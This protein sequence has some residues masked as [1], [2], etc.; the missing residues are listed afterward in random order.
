MP[1]SH[2]DTT[3]SLVPQNSHVGWGVEV[4][5]GRGADCSALQRCREVEVQTAL[6][7]RGGGAEVQG[8]EV[9]GGH[10]GGVEDEG[11]DGGVLLVHGPPLVETHLA[12]YSQ[13][14]EQLVFQETGFHLVLWV[15]HPDLAPD[16]AAGQD[17][18]LLVVEGEGGPG[19]RV[20]VLLNVLVLVLHQHRPRV[21]VDDADTVAAARRHVR[22]RLGFVLCIWLEN[23]LGGH[24]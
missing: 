7:C 19:Q 9:Q 4:Q 8:A 16:A 17:V 12:H 3:P 6:Y 2:S 22:R 11:V 18:G 13:N 1:T 14:Q 23:N 21:D 5:R 15:E 10:L 24:I 20:E